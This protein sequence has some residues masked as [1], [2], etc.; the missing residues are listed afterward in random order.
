MAIS[1]T[2]PER[3]LHKQSDVGG[4]SDGYTY[5]NGN[6][7]GPRSAAEFEF[8]MLVLC[9]EVPISIELFFWSARTFYLE[10]SLKCVKK[11]RKGSFFSLFIRKRMR[12]KK[13]FF[14]QG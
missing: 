1:H 11:N 14:V 3:N 8:D 4:G 7:Q 13:H 2:E 12:V 6:N 10:K 9:I 5:E